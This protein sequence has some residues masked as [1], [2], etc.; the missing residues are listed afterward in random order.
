MIR[1]IANVIRGEGVMSAVRRTG[2]RIEEA[3]KDVAMRMRSV[4][5]LPASEPPGPPDR[6]PGG[7][8]AR[9]TGGH[10]AEILNFSASSIAPR[11]GGVAIQL[12]TRLRAERA[13]RNVALL[14]P[15]GLDIGGHRRRAV[16]IDDAMKITGAKA[17]HLEGTSNAPLAELLRF[18]LIVS[19]HDLTLF[20]VDRELARRV[21][22]EAKA[23]I[24]PS[25]FL[26]EKHRELLP[27]IE[28]EIIE[29]AIGHPPSAQPPSGEAIAFAG[30]V[31]RHKGAHLLPDI[32]RS[33]DTELHVFG[34]GDVD[35]FRPLR[36][37]PNVV[38]HGYYRA[39]TL[40]SLL[41]R[42]RIGLVV[43][44]S[45]VPE[46]YSLVLSEAW[47]AGA[48]VAAFDAGAL[49]ERILARGG[50]WLAPP[51]SGARGLIDIIRLWTAAAAPPLS[52][53]PQSKEVIDVYRK[54]GLLTRHNCADSSS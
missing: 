14:H 10:H 24:F 44:P 5:S 45:I 11:T 29:P 47:Q 33:L 23:L 13:L 8:E 54:F 48:S 15:G 53:A 42:H 41:A 6:F 20:D 49:G 2:E 39:G 26:L 51:G 17:I 31:K 40:P 35:L 3:A 46:S 36:A 4:L 19:I 37:L 9:T 27:S 1:T 22:A 50:G 25:R 38:I 18:P 28:G 43:L 52:I 32:A 12:M 21:L 34:G 16:T 7:R 30:A